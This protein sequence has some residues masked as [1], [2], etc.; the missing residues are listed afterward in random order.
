MLLL[1]R[2]PYL[3]PPRQVID[4]V[5][6][7]AGTANQGIISLLM[8]VERPAYIPTVS[9]GSGTLG[10]VDELTG[11]HKTTTSFVRLHLR[12]L[13]L[14]G[15]WS[16]AVPGDSDSAWLHLACMVCGLHRHSEPHA[17]HLE[18]LSASRNRKHASFL[19][20]VAS[21]S[22]YVGASKK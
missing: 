3:D 15:R 20:G 11:H 10:G 9:G 19:W 2:H 17:V 16:Q 7:R 6:L 12:A 5:H 1:W 14:C 22:S 8:Q 13:Q 18:C 21:V 4:V